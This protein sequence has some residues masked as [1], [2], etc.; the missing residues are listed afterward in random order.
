M[1]KPFLDGQVRA[2]IFCHANIETVITTKEGQPSKLQNYPSLHILP[3]T[4]QTALQTSPQ[5]Q[6]PMILSTSNH[7]N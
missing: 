2:N 3:T 4:H 5:S 7:F 6:K 1:D